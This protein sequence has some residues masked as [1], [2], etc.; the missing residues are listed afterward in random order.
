[1]KKWTHVGWAVPA[2]VAILA[3]STSGIAADRI[4]VCEEFGR[5]T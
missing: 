2:L 1:M 4:V 5:T 3:L